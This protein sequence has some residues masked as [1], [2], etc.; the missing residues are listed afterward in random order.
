MAHVSDWWTF[1]GFLCTLNLLCMLPLSGGSSKCSINTLIN[2]QELIDN[3]RETHLKQHLRGLTNLYSC[4]FKKMHGV[5][6]LSDR[7]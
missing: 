6:E 4:I 3:A 7:M 5:I 2:L 1:Q